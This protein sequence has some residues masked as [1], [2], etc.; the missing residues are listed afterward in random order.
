MSAVDIA[1][2]IPALPL[3]GFIVIV[4]FTRVMD[5][6]SRP[7]SAPMGATEAGHP[8]G[9]THEEAASADRGPTD[10]PGAP[11]GGHDVDT[12]RAA[13]GGHDATGSAVHDAHGVS[14]S[15]SAQ[16]DDS[17]HGGH[18]EHGG[19]TSRWGKISGY[20]SI[21]SMLAAWVLSLII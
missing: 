10:K 11:A 13:H 16:H 4:F 21:L 1:W 18:G 5:V 20:V 6:R 3:A 17:T 9:L 2:L 15:G 8:A 12:L 7:V 14:A 19:E